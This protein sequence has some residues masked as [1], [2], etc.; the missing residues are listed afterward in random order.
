MNSASIKNFLA[1][2][3]IVCWVLIWITTGSWKVEQLCSDVPAKMYKCTLQVPHITPLGWLFGM[4]K[5]MSIPAFEQLLNN[6]VASLSPNQVPAI[7]LGLN[8]KPIWGGTL[9]KEWEKNCDQ[10]WTCT[11]WVIHVKAI[12]EIAL[13]SKAF[14]EKGFAFLQGLFPHKPSS[15]FGFCFTEESTS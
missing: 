9:K 2:T 13:T 8:F 11:K 3:S 5:D 12:A 6:K 14:P 1:V 15:P 4:H 10:D 7:Q